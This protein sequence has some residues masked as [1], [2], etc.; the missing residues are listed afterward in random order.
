[1]YSCTLQLTQHAL[2]VIHASGRAWVTANIALLPGDFS[3][4]AQ[5]TVSMTACPDVYTL[6]LSGAV[7]SMTEPY[8]SFLLLM[9]KH[10]LNI[11][12]LPVITVLS[13]V[14]ALSQLLADPSHAVPA[15]LSIQIGL[16]IPGSS[17]LC[18]LGLILSRVTVQPAI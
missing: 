1:M 16:C 12:S 2:S 17:C 18:Q 7:C 14:P 6:L 13:V 5:S 3:K 9:L 15:G 4:L 11:Q 10:P 8:R